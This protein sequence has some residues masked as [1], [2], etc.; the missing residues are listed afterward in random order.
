MHKTRKFNLSPRLL[1]LLVAAVI[2]SQSAFA[3]AVCT[4][5]PARELLIRDL[6]VVEDCT[7]T[8][9]GP[10]PNGARANAA[11]TFGR[12]MEGLAGTTDKAAL[13]KFVLGWLA[14]WEVPQVINSNV[15]PARPFIRQLV[16]DP[17]L[18]A[19][20]GTVLDM[21]KAP[22]RLLSIVARLDLRKNPSYG[23]L[24]AG[25]ARFV[26]GV[27]DI[28]N[29]QGAPLFT[30]ILEYGLKADTCDDQKKWAQKFHALGGIPFGSTYNA[31][32]QSVTDGFTK[33]GSNPLKPN[34]SALN[35]LRTNEIALSFPWEL[36]EFTLQPVTA[37]D[38]PIAPLKEATVKQTPA[39][40][41]NGGTL[42]AD[43]INEH[44]AEILLQ[45]H[46]V[47][48]IYQGQHFLGGSS[49]NQIDFWNAPGINNNNARHLFSLNTCNA[50]HGRETNTGFLQISPRS[51]GSV[52]S[53]S[54]F[55]S[56]IDVSDPVTGE[57]RHFNEL[58]FRAKDLCRLLTQP[59]SV[60][61]TDPSTTRVE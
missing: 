51:P 39:N 42:V 56:G 29:P 23:S 9:W 13:S 26:F 35:Q 5:D 58:E 44:E 43:F 46:V 27:L 21:K 38:A 11:W 3:Q 34:G 59:C 40:V 4:V 24:N 37:S 20:G 16:T 15:V 6:S 8:T 36:R 2:A 53:I 10:C 33:I 30:V 50:C 49:L 47:P 18:Q 61:A 31:T 1:V 60:L 22:F 7:R 25:E 14:H 57:I 28:N 12:L 32:L 45:Q 55:L 41:F 54:G 48:E 17:W 19:S 52:S